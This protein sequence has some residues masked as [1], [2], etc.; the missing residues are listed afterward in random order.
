M[1]GDIIE[2][3][4]T[5][6][7]SNTLYSLS[8]F[9]KAESIVFHYLILQIKSTQRLKQITCKGIFKICNFSLLAEVFDNCEMGANR[10]ACN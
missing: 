1:L 8:M 7:D 4:N 6:N 5:Y 10:N 3:Y 9:L 2:N